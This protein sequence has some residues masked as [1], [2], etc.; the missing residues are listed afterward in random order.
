MI[1]SICPYCNKCTQ[2]EQI[3]KEEILVVKQ[4]DILVL[5]KYLE[6]QECKNKFDDPKDDYDVIEAGYLE[7]NRLYPNDKVRIRSRDDVLNE[8][9]I[10]AQDL[11]MGY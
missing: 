5:D 10:D 1:N 9:A 6:C 4:R 8:M 3:E 2:C 11:N 7:H